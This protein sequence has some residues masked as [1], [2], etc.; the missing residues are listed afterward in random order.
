MATERELKFSTTDEHVPSLAELRAALGAS[1]LELAPAR[2]KRHLD[3][4]Y[5]D[6]SGGLERAGWAL[7]R[8]RS[9]GATVV[10]LKGE[11]T[12]TGAL[13]ARRE[14]EV[15]IDADSGDHAVTWPAAITAA[16]PASVDT[17]EL[18]AQAELRVRR[19]AIGATMNGALV[20]EL[21]FDEVTCT[22]PE[23]AASAATLRDSPRFTF[24]EV[25]IEAIA[26]PAG[27][28]VSLDAMD[29]LAAVVRTVLPLTESGTSKLQRA[30][31]L[32]APFL[33]EEFARP[34]Q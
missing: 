23:A 30:R 18:T 1:G 20:A 13:H 34:G 31:V 24:Y 6:A 3:V 17:S 32:L 26:N 29:E 21:A 33:D 15:E 5:D 12:V 7:R 8:R 2:V 14:V 22:P 4:Y 28:Q 10:A 19:V 25:E 27:D 11:A 16:L 9:A